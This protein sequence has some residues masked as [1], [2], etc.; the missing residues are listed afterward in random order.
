MIFIHAVSSPGEIRVAV[1]DSGRLLDFSIFR[2][3]AP[4][5]VG[6]ILRGRVISMVPAMG[7]AFVRLPDAEGFL[8]DSE[9]AAG[10]SEGMS[11]GVRITRAAQGGKG[12]RLSARLEAAVPGG[13][14]ALLT[15]GPGPVERFSRLYPEASIF[16]DDPALV[17]ELRPILGERISIRREKLED[18]LENAIDALTR[19]DAELPGGA[20]MSV[21]PTPA[22]V[23]IDIDAG[24][25]TAA[26]GQK[27]VSQMSLNRAAIP[28]IVAQIRLR[29]LSGA[30]LIDFAGM[31]TSRRLA[32]G[33]AFA[34]AL[35]TDP[36]RPRFLG[37]TALGLAEISRPRI[38]P[39][40]HE[41][42]TGPHAAGLR[43]LRAIMAEPARNQTLVASPAIVSALTADTV[44]LDDFPRMTGRRAILRSDPGLSG[45]RLE[46]G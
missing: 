15:R 3:G 5:G 32:L 35:A 45:W 24:R 6:D 41:L 4:D 26:R 44:A 13:P 34:E 17:A 33:P 30:I 18:A 25:A 2:R 12:P 39:P 9:G 43:G 21:W 28:A 31:K 42:L 36:L 23:A 10:L 29:N 27:A 20:R 40:L 37:F 38:H 7:G 1:T 46:D 22:L 16:A 19:T 8:P 14:V 11:I